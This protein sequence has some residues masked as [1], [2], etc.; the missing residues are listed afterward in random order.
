MNQDQFEL[1]PYVEPEKPKRGR[2]VGA[3]NLHKEAMVYVSIRIP[4][5]V[6]AFYSQFNNR[7]AVIREALQAYIEQD[8]K[9]RVND[10]PNQ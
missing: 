1:T 8:R 3:K 4:K 6:L 7:Q 10:E 5:E 9:E 2:P